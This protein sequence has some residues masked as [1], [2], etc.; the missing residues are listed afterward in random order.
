MNPWYSAKELA[1]LDG[2]PGTISCVIRKAK[3]DRYIA[4]HRQGKGGGKEYHLSCLPTATKDH[5]HRIAMEESGKALVATAKSQEIAI[6]LDEEPA[7]LATMKQWQ[8]DIFNARVILYREFE[9]LQA[10]FGTTRAWQKLVAMARYEQLPEHLQK[11]VPVANARSGKGNGDG[12]RTL[13][14]STIL[15]WQRIV[16]EKG[17][18]GLAPKGADRCEIPAWA[19]YFLKCY[20]R[21][22]KPSVAVAIEEMAKILPPEIP[23]PSVSQVYRFQ[24]KRHAVDREKGRHS[25]HSLKKFKGFVRRST[26]NLLP[27]DI[28]QCDGHS[29][30]AR[31]AHPEHGRPFHPEVCGVVDWKTRVCTGWSAWL[32]ESALTVSGAI[33]H[34]LQVTEEKPYGGTFAILYFDRGAGNTSHIVSDEVVGVLARAGTE[35]QEGLPGNS[36]GRGLIERSNVS[37]WIN[38]A[39]K[40]ETYTGEDMD[41]T[42]AREIYLVMDREVKK[43]GT[44]T[45][46]GLLSWEKFLQL[47]QQTVDEYNRR[48]HRGLPKITDPNTGR[49]RH[50]APLEMWAQHLFE[51]WQPSVLPA[52][53]L[54]DLQRPQMVRKTNR[55]EVSLFGNTYYNRGLEGY[56]GHDV[57]VEYDVHDAREVKVRDMTH[58]LICMAQFE[59]NVR[60]AFPVSFVEHNRKQR[61][62]RRMDLIENKREEILAE[63]RGFIELAP[64]AEVIELHGSYST[65]TVDKEALLLEMQSQATL[66]RIPEDDKGKY[67]FWNELDNRIKASKGLNEKEL[68][69]Y[70]SYPS[71]AS[72]KAFRMVSETLGQQQG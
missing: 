54:S 30:K 49:K 24:N 48:P 7:D 16:K 71:S 32:S 15:K 17:L 35:P 67:Q 70:S 51:G 68:L 31:I 64:R 58:R 19:P 1:G 26:E 53:I 65:I 40:L 57:I 18:E 34:S 66:I 59:R 62:K 4:R 38:A 56:H 63:E 29:F 33:I 2:M 12:G 55:C 23:V 28:G 25:A 8:R 11:L 44:C 3:N 6:V 69:F 37:L 20:Q 10:T 13:S 45:H 27:L 41:S 9:R 46:Q 50:M 72:Y 14:K 52:E 22:Q 21:P 5:L 36:Q 39:K 47:C 42:K 60:D 43:T 61:A